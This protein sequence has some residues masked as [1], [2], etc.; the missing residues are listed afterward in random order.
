M[1]SI[2][3]KFRNE[4]FINLQDKY[5]TEEIPLKVVLLYSWEQ[6]GFCFSTINI[7]SPGV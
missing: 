4:P 6:L 5:S 2:G 3:L 7:G 1:Y